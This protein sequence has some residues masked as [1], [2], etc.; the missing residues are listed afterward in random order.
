[1]GP[2][3]TLMALGANI[4]AVDLDRPNIWKRLITIAEQSCGTMTFPLKKPQ[5]DISN[6][7]E[8]Y[9]NAG[10]NLM[11]G[12]P[13][14]FNWL[15]TVYPDK[16]ITVGCYVYLDGEA[17]VRVA[18]AC[19]AVMKGLSEVRKKV[20]LAFL[21]TP[22][23][24]HVI[25]E[26]ARRTALANYNSFALRNLIV[27]PIRLLAGGRMLVKNAQPPVK[28]KDGKTFAYADEILVN[29][30]PNYILAKRMQ[31]WRAIV[32]RYDKQCSVSSH[33]APSTSTASV[34]SNRQFAWAYDG[35][36]FF[37]PIEI[38]T[39]ETSNAVMCA[40]LLHDLNNPKAVA[41]PDVP[42]GNPLELFKHNSFHGG[43]WRAGYKL[44]SIGEVSVLVHFFKVLKV[45]ILL[46]LI[47]VVVGIFWKTN[48]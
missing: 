34:V 43:L 13:E 40:I 6:N 24:C 44:N 29:Q 23:D 48:K 30:G 37:Q 1:M 46:A 31:H 42:L 17:H 36:P 32:A 45:Y 10:G 8:L 35:M 21:C 11:T 27:L 38:F 18:L 3:L 9:D 41:N 25:P 20:T 33:I 4:I 2:F 15:K 28:A 5:K 39:Q 22:T 26:E 47:A 14:I 12:V 19:D 16:P 7:D